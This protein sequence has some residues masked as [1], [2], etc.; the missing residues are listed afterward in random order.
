MKT[1][2]NWEHAGTFSFPHQSVVWQTCIA[3]ESRLWSDSWA[4]SKQGHT[5]AEPWG[6][7]GIWM[8]LLWDFREGC[9]EV[10]C[11]WISVLIG[12]QSTLGPCVKGSILGLGCK[13]SCQ[14]WLQVNIDTWYIYIYILNIDH[15]M[16]PETP[17]WTWDRLVLCVEETNQQKGISLFLI[18]FQ[19]TKCLLL[20]FREQSFSLS[21]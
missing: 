14:S 3:T 2:I 18:H 5:V 15:L 13:G 16:C 11:W 10:K 21:R 1:S 7:S 20:D 19:R 12:S 6:I 8:S 9:R 17:R 4:F